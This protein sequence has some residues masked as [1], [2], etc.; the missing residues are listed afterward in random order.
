MLVERNSLALKLRLG[1]KAARVRADAID[2]Q[3]DKLKTEIEEIVGAIA[4]ALEEAQ[5]AERREKVAAEIEKAA[6]TQVLLLERAKLAML[7]DDAVSVLIQATDRWVVT[8]MEMERLCSLAPSRFIWG[9][10]PVEMLV[11]AHMPLGAA[12]QGFPAPAGFE[13]AD[14]TK[15]RNWIDLVAHVD[16]GAKAW[17]ERLIP[18][19]DIQAAAD[20]AKAA[21]ATQEGAGDG[22]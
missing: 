21:Q 7:L 14:G 9:H 20:A 19:A 17:A 1:Q 2:V 10:G 11:Q 13:K 15:T 4:G 18:L 8:S 16:R 6:N 3:A 5:E 22:A 12:I